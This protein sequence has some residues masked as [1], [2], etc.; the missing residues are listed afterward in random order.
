M[1]CFTWRRSRWCAES[2]V[3]PVETYDVN[4]MGTVHVLEAVRKTPSV[5]ATVVITSDKCYENRE[6]MTPYREGDANG[7][8]RSL[9]QLQGLRRTGHGRLWQILFRARHGARVSC[10]GSCW[11]RDRRAVIGPRTASSAIWRVG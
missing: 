7:R 2:Y 4:V 8:A 9:F 6:T 5:S 3:I 10:L 11:Q 1:W